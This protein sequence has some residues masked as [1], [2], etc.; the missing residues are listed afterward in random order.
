MILLLVACNPTTDDPPIDEDCEPNQIEIDG[1]CVTLSGPELQLRQA[2]LGM[3][4]KD[5][6]E[7]EV[8]ITD[9]AS[10]EYDLL[11]ATDGDTSMMADVAETIYTIQ[12]DTCVEHIWKYGS[13]STTTIPCDDE[14]P[15][16]RAFTYDMFTLS[17]GIYQ[18]DDTSFSVVED[19]FGTI[20]PDATLTSLSLSITDDA[21]DRITMVFDRTD[22]T[23]T[24]VYDFTNYDGV[25]IVIPTQE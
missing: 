21:I 25:T 8:T 19:T 15:F 24:I 7:I 16:Y 6:Y 18:L 3:A 10:I 23:Y 9:P 13:L 20:L 11:I 17:S 1:E 4:T 5:N 22:G 14:P 12:G 2:L